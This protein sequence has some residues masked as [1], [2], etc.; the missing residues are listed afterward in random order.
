MK[1]KPISVDEL[2]WVCR[3]SKTDEPDKL[4]RWARQ[5]FFKD[6]HIAWVR[7]D[8]FKGIVTF[9]VITQFPVNGNDMPHYIAPFETFKGAKECVEF[10]WNQFRE[11]CK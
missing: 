6:L 3:Y 7:R 2:S 11:L 9:K 10:F 4:G 1:K 5:C 8:E